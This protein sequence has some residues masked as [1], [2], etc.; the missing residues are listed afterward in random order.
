MPATTYYAPSPFSD[1]S[2]PYQG[3]QQQQFWSAG[4]TLQQAEGE[5]HGVQ[6]PG[7]AGIHPGY[8][9]HDGMLSHTAVLAACSSPLDSC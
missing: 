9:P 4:G 5:S 6:S 3:F 1:I 2:N 8:F 7:L